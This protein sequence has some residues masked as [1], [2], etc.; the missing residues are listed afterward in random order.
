M[1][2]QPTWLCLHLRQ[3]LRLTKCHIFG[4]MHPSR[5]HN[6]Q[7]CILPRLVRC[8]YPKFHHPMFTRLK[9]SCWHTHKQTHKQTDSG[10]N[11]LC[12]ATMLGNY[13]V[14][15]GNQFKNSFP[16]LT[17]VSPMKSIQTNWSSILH[18]PDSLSDGQQASNESKKITLA[19]YEAKHWKE[20]GLWWQTFTFYLN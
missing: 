12:Y 19:S 5:G 3:A 4:V 1:F 7:I 17:K 13:T 20:S 6:P 15:T 16:G 14:N 9:L 2:R 10:K 11:V 8:V 18:R